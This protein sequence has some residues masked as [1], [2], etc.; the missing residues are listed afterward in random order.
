MY[1]NLWSDQFFYYG[2]GLYNSLKA[3]II[4]TS[5]VMV[6]LVKFRYHSVCLLPET[7]AMLPLRLVP[8]AWLTVFLC[9]PGLS[10]LCG[11][12]LAHLLFSGVPG[13][14]VERCSV[15][16]RAQ[17]FQ[18][19]PWIHGLEPS[20]DLSISVFMLTEGAQQPCLCEV[21]IKAS[22][23]PPGDDRM[24]IIHHDCLYSEHLSS[25][26]IFIW[27]LSASSSGFLDSHQHIPVVFS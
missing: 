14:I 19:M 16:C 1:N 22:C 2:L 3:K 17:R 6:A 23:L 5:D 20:L 10:C 13:W 11:L 21:E 24:V 4:W 15:C 8:A 18:R 12:V 27:T 7:Q 25:R 9:P 26:A